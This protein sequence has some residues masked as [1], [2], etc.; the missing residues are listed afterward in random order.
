MGFFIEVEVPPYCLIP[1][2]NTRCRFYSSPLFRKKRCT[3][4]NVQLMNAKNYPWFNIV[5]PCKQCEKMRVV[6]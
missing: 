4:F 1:I 5:L 2:H 6:K 3:R